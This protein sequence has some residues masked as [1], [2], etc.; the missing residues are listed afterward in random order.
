MLRFRFAAVVF[1]FVSSAAILGFKVSDPAG[2]QMKTF[3]DSFLESLNEKERSLATMPFDSPQRVGWHFIPKDD[4]KGMP[5][6][7]MNTAQQAAARRLLRAALSEAGYTKATKIMML[8]SVLRELE[9]PGSEA[10]RDPLKYYVT[11]FGKPSNEQPWGLSFEGHHLSLNFT[12]REGKVVDSTP[13]FFA[14]N[15]ATIQN[16]VSGPLTKGTRVLRDEE[17]LAFDL[18]NSLND[19]QLELALIAE[20]APAEIRFAGE[21][22]SRVGDPEGIAQR[23]MNAKQQKTLMALIQSY[24]DAM[25][26][27]VRKQRTEIMTVGGVENIRF[28]WAGAR[29]PGV[30]HYY[31]VR[32]E[33]F[34]IEF[35]NTQADAAGNPAN[36]IHCVWR[37]LTGDF[38]LPIG[39]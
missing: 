16:D 10:R 20:E 26:E 31:K 37:D 21:A 39:E 29:K 15:P 36:H 30:G 11:I 5:L 7:Q 19:S 32:G 14:A 33:Q 22:Q 24:I 38:D 27:T 6:N 28:A 34:L 3:A 2:L 8:E 1:V 18:V 13:Q 35:V 12:C 9:G 17:Q 25:P 23:R 4:R